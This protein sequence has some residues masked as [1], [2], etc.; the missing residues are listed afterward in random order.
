MQLN[1]FES[2][3]ASEYLYL[4]LE[5]VQLACENEQLKQQLAKLQNSDK[6]TTK[7]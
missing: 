6:K 3:L 1:S 7:K 2:K 4:K 5:N